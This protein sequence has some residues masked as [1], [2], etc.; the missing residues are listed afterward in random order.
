MNEGFVGTMYAFTDDSR[1]LNDPED[2]VFYKPTWDYQTYYYDTDF[3]YL[4][5]G[6]LIIDTD[7]DNSYLMFMGSD[8]LITKIDTSVN[9]DR[10]L[11]LIK[12]SYGNAEV[13][14]FTGSFEHIFVVDMRY[15][16][17]NLVNFIKEMGVTDVLFSMCSYSVV[18]VNA[19]ELPVMLVQDADSQ[20][21]DEGPTSSV[22]L[23]KTAPLLSFSSA[24][25]ENEE[26][27]T[28][29]ETT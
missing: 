15:F 29:E 11:L 1:V 19:E 26:E 6:D 7:V 21:V 3:E 20:I 4:Y 27:Y 18:G 14:F 28:D 16:D 12:D 17:R 22:G 24:A 9:N 25:E 23:P 8:S 5:E 2:F 10:V 13:P